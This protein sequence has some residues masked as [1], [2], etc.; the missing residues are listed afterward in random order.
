MTDFPAPFT[1]TVYTSTCGIP[2]LLYTWNLKKIPSCINLEAII[3]STSLGLTHLFEH[4]FSSDWLLHHSPWTEYS[5]VTERGSV[6]VISF[7]CLSNDLYVYLCLL[8]SVSPSVHS[9][10]G[11]FQESIIYYKMNLLFVLDLIS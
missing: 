6:V 9:V 5:H 11:L 4:H 3:E 1:C 7:V 8:M 2:S 10:G